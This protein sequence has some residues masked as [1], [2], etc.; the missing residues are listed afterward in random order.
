MKDSR[1]ATATKPTT[2]PTTNQTEAVVRGLPAEAEIKERDRAIIT[3]TLL[4]GARDGAIAPLKITHINMEERAVYP[5]VRDVNTKFSKTCHLL[6]CR[7]IDFAWSFRTM[8]AS[9]YVNERLD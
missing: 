1:I 4:S 7:Q 9:P 3:F 2:A 5:D 6:L 8:D